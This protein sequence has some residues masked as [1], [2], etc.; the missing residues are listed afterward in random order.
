MIQSQVLVAQETAQTEMEEW[1]NTQ[2]V[3]KLPEGY[4][5]DNRWVVPTDEQLRH[6][7]LSQYHDS[8][9]AGHPRRDNTIALVA[10]RYWW[11][12][13]NIWIK[14]YIKGCTICQQNKIQTMK[15]KMPLYHLPGDLTECPF[16]TVTMDN[17]C[18]P[19][20]MMQYLPLWIKD[21]HEQQHSSHAA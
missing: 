17:Y 14:Q 12:K 4:I 6:D 11:P 2:G 5:K 19:M 3:R 1:C 13:M 10:R 16:N 20:V 7:V 8:P 21:V 18:H 9:M 15:N